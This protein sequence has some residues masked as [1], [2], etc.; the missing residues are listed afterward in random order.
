MNNYSYPIQE[1]LTKNINDL[2][3]KDLNLDFINN[4]IKKH[5]YWATNSLTGKSYW[6]FQQNI[7]STDWIMGFV[8]PQEETLLNRKTEQT[9]SIIFVVSATFA[10]LFFLCLLFVS[11]YRYDHTRALDARGYF[12]I[13]LYPEDRLYV[14]PYY[15]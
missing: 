9:H 4:N 6:V 14:A 1:Y 7:P 15:E 13:T 3:K 2:A 8:L 12:F 5:D 10:F 11:I